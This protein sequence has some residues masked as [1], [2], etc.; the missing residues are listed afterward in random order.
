MKFC[1]VD[2]PIVSLA[3]HP[4]RWQPTMVSWLP[5]DSKL[6]CPSSIVA[7]KILHRPLLG[8]LASH[9]HRDAFRDPEWQA[10]LDS[11]LQRAKCTGA[12]IIFPHAAPYSQAIEFACDRYGISCFAIR[13]QVGMQKLVSSDREIEAHVLD[14]WSNTRISEKNTNPADLTVCVLADQIVALNVSPN[15]KVASLIQRRLQ[16]PEVEPSSVW[17]QAVQRPTKAQREL[18]KNCNQLG[19]VLWF[20]N[21]AAVAS[22]NPMGCHARTIPSTHQIT[23]PIPEPL[24]NSDVYLVHTTRARQ[25]NWPEQ[26]TRDLLDESFRCEWSPNQT[27]LDTLLRIVR[28]QRIIATTARKRG[29]LPTVS[30]T[31][32]NLAELTKMRAFQSHLARWDWEPYGI[33]VLRSVLERLGCRPV[34][35]L[36]KQQIDLLDPNEQAFCQPTAQEQGD[37][38]WTSEREW[39]LPSDLRLAHLPTRGVFIFVSTRSEALAMAHYTRWPVYWLNESA[40][41]L[42]G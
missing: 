14:I 12:S 28:S 42:S 7:Q 39:R 16:C 24:R 21:H 31:Q 30:F 4:Q 32:N 17:I 3:S 26:S 23:G 2:Q 35:Y 11:V 5:P 27:P 15:G 18:L 29:Q 9:P 25:S 19:A 40:S 6:V 38:D 1:N 36:P 13:S 33:A 41:V 10:A 37:R 22:L 8:I 20:P 34:C